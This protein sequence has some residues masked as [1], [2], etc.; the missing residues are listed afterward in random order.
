MDIAG[1][2]ALRDDPEVRDIEAGWADNVLARADK[3][4]DIAA[5][6]TLL[7]PVAQDLRSTPRGAAMPPTS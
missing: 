7:S 1:S 3:E 5:R 2:P 6:R 4:T